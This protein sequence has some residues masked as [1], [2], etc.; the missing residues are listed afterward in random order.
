[1]RA[2]L[3]LLWSDSLMFGLFALLAAVLGRDLDVGIAL[4]VIL[5]FARWDHAS[6]MADVTTQA[7][8][9]KEELQRMGVLR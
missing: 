2:F 9:V 1:M 8:E 4:L 6:S 7:R 3:R 5:L